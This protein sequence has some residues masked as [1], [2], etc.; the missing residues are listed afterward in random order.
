MV[1]ETSFAKMV[2]TTCSKMIQAN[3]ADCFDEAQRLRHRVLLPLALSNNRYQKD[4]TSLLY[5]IEE[6]AS[7]VGFYINA[8]KTEFIYHNQDKSGGMIT[9]NGEKIKSV[10]KFKYLGRYIAST[11]R[12]VN[13]RLGKAW[14][15]LDKYGNPIF[16][17]GISSEQP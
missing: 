5:K 11:K 13:I 1:G 10:V 14:G 15:A 16:Q 3:T 2:H 8:S 17:K 7:E 9:L 12:D 6:V 4:A